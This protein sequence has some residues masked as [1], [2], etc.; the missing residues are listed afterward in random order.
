MFLFHII[1]CQ[2]PIDCTECRIGVERRGG[3]NASRKVRRLLGKSEDD[4]R[5]PCAGNF[6][7]LDHGRR[8]V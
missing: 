2:V 5:N 7:Q 8:A 1:D 3:K 4:D 6:L